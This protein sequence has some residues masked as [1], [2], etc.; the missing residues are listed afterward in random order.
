[1]TRAA[2]LLLLFFF[3]LY[4]EAF[5]ADVRKDLKGIR[6]EIKK[7]A[8]LLNSTK[9]IEK[10]VSGELALIEKGLREKETALRRLSGELMRLQQ[11]LLSTR[12]Q[13]RTTQSD[14]DRK[15]QDIRARLVALY[16]AGDIGPVRIFFSSESFPQ[17]LESLLYMR[18]ILR[19]DRKMIDDSAARITTLTLLKVKL[20]EDARK[21]EALRAGI[22]GKKREIEVEKKRKAAYLF[23]VKQEKESYMAA[24]RHLEANAGRLQAMM[25]KLE[26]QSRKSYSRKSH[27]RPAIRETTF[28]APG[29]VVVPSIGFGGRKQQL[30]LPVR[31]EVIQRFGRHKH[32]EFNT[33]TFSNGLAIA[34]SVG[35]DIHAVDGGTV[36]F[37]DYFKG[38]GNMVILDHGDGFF[39]VYAHASRLA[40]KEGSRIAR[41]DVIASVGDLD[42]SRGPMLYFEIR[43]LGKPVDPSPWFK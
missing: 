15:H 16:K 10:Q 31:G 38:Y 18:A 12:R 9:K 8:L 2:T 39:S 22:E 13:T 33:F 37:A 5:S 35:A 25:Q 23:K 1:M 24:L 19:G 20:E 41:N 28:P 36:I 29:Q 27:P 14:V 32:P 7:K 43:Y 30:P 3:C 34:A 40:K 11:S 4:R 21:T 26:A 17:M 42:S 6:Q